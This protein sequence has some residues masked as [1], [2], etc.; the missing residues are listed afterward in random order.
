MAADFISEAEA[1]KDVA[2]F[3]DNM[4]IRPVRYYTPLLRFVFANAKVCGR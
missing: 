3:S 2:G 4:S 1:T